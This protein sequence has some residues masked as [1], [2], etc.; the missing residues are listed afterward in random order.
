[1]MAEARYTCSACGR[2]HTAD[3][4]EATETAGF[5]CRVSGAPIVAVAITIDDIAPEDHAA[6][7]ITREDQREA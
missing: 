4:V 6:T 3:E 1:M 7:D 2:E 5:I